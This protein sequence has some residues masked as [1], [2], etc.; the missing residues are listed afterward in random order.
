MITEPVEWKRRRCRAVVSHISRKTSEIWG[1]RDL[2]SGKNPRF[3]TGKDPRF[4][5]GKDPRFVIG[6]DPRFVIGKEA[7]VS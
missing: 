2:L 5:T 4:V 6:K 7:E 3:V 1:T